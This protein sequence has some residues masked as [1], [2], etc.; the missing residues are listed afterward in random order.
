VPVS[1]TIT[2]DEEGVVGLAWLAFSTEWIKMRP[3]SVVSTTIT[4]TEHVIIHST[5]GVVSL[6]HYR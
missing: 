2:C 4:Y 1:G 5:I 3:S 6:D